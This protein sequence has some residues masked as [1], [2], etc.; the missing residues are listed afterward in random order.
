MARTPKPWFRED[1]QVYAVIIGGVRHNLGPDKKEADRKFHE[2]MARRDEPKPPSAPTTSGL[3]VGEVYEKFLGWCQKHRAPRTYEWTLGHVQNF[4]DHLKTARTMPAASLR[5]FHVV[6]WTDSKPTW[7]PNH[8][9]GAIVAVTRP[10]NWAAK[11]GYIDRNPV[12]GVEKPSP[13]KRTS[14]MT[15]ADFALLLSHVKDEPFRDL[16]T[17]AYEAGVRPQEA[18]HVEARHLRTRAPAGGNPAGGGQGEAAVAGHLPVRRRPRHCRPV[19]R[20]ATDRAA[21]PQPGRQPVEGPGRR[22]P[23]PAVAGQAERR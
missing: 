11:L 15:P 19:G 1:K 7:G 17:F 23:V 4:C 18:R 20:P 16:L 6:E 14:R 22:V 5:P 2:L 9:R 21:V 12:A 3:T 13:V 10:F 8:K